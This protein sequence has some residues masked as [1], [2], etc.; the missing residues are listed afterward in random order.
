MG[1][2][3]FERLSVWWLNAWL[4]SIF[5]LF[6]SI[7]ANW[8][9]LSSNLGPMSLLVKTANSMVSF[10][11]TNPSFVWQFWSKGHKLVKLWKYFLQTHPSHYGFICSHLFSFILIH[12]CLFGFIQDICPHSYWVLMRQSSVIGYV[13]DSIWLL[14]PGNPI[15]PSW[16]TFIMKSM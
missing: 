8:G 5:Y 3:W 12:A 6:G 15:E 2:M 10:I 9:L 14:S 11:F 16:M 7:V 13:N 1:I 4:F